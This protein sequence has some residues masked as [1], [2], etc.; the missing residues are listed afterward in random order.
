MHDFFTS[1]LWLVIS[2]ILTVL[3]ATG[4]IVGFYQNSKSRKSLREYTYLFKIA[5]QHIDLENKENTIKNYNKQISEMRKTLQNQIPKE[6]EKIALQGILKNEIQA[7]SNTYTKVKSLQSQIEDINTEETNNQ[8]L[9]EEVRKTIE[10]TYSYNRSN[11]F[12]NSLFFIVSIISSFL[13]MILPHN[14]YSLAVSVILCFQLYFGI[15]LLKNYIKN[16]YNKKE[17]MPIKQKFKISISLGFFIVTIFLTIVFTI[18]INQVNLYK[19]NQTD[20]ILTIL[21]FYLIHIIFGCMYFK[22]EKKNKTL[23]YIVMILNTIF[24]FFN[25]IFFIL[26]KSESA[27]I[28]FLLFSIPTLIIECF[29]LISHCF[30]SK[31]NHKCI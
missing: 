12:F 7:L 4:T 3:G 29:I 15:R 27:F 22:K 16:N 11:N 5:G 26:S 30:Y 2:S 18:Y 23:W 21:A 17:L 13:S 10:P 24:Y 6:A 9:L 8:E 31:S 14:L 1:N 19:S 20:I 28:A 25:F